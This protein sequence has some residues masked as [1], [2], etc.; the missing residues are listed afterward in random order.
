MRAK[1]TN[2][3]IFIPPEAHVGRFAI[4]IRN[5]SFSN[6][7]MEPLSS[8]PLAQELFGPGELFKMITCS[9]K[10]RETKELMRSSWGKTLI[11]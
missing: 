4:S 1:A 11:P 3:V 9:D 2:R 6:N 5:P 10:P 7:V 8:S